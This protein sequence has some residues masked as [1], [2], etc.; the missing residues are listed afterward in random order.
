MELREEFLYHIWDE[1]HLRNEL[2]TVSGKAVRIVYPGQYNTNRGP[3]F[4]N[5]AVIIDGEHLTGSVEIHP[6]TYD[7]IAHHH[8][9]NPY[10]NKVILHVVFEHRGRESHTIRE[11]GQPIEILELKDQL[12]E[13]INKLFERHKTYPLKGQSSYCDLLSL[14]PS[15]H[16]QSILR[17]YGVQRFENKV[18]RF[19]TSLLNSDFDQILYEGFLEAMG[20]DKNKYSFITIAQTL[21]WKKLKDWYEEGMELDDLISVMTVSSG[22]LAVSSNYLPA[23]LVSDIQKRYEIQNYTA[24]RIHAL[25]QKFRIRPANHPI[26]RMIVICHFLYRIL[27]KGFVYHLLPIF[28]E[29]IEYKDL[30]VRFKRLLAF[31]GT[32][33]DSMIPR[34]GDNHLRTILI[35]IVLPIAFLYFQ[36]TGDSEGTQQILKI[37][38]NHPALADNYVIN[39]MNKYL[40]PG[41]QKLTAGSAMIQQG[42]IELYFRFCQ[43]HYCDD[44]RQ[45]F[46][47]SDI[48]G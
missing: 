4:F 10:Y 27:D 26:Y 43:Y 32:Y 12:V 37:Y 24:Q 17:K 8:E 47:R 18:K 48:E 13:D 11:D 3:D 45:T 19:N 23:P 9:E 34:L 41:Q 30:F 39:F 35:N 38:E 33:H 36:K 29:S 21:T 2:V 20:Y 5:A 14:I 42:L 40:S 31:S 25:W 15:D 7:W 16:L 1:G 28:Q 22:L 6:N 46:G 44:C